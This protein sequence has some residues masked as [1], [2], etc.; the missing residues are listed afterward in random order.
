MLFVLKCVLYGWLCCCVVAV[1]W[2]VYEGR[3][4][5]WYDGNDNEALEGNDARKS[6]Q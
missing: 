2:F 1:L 3:R 5:V 4:A 6:E